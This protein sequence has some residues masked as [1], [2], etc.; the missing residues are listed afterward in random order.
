MKRLIR[1]HGPFTLGAA[2]GCAFG[3]ALANLGTHFYLDAA[4]AGA[5]GVAL[6]VGAAVLYTETDRRESRSIGSDLEWLESSRKMRRE[7]LK[8][9]GVV[10]PRLTVIRGEKAGL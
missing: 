6:W 7:L 4:L 10:R 2:G 3:L 9:S 5:A 8:A 1:R